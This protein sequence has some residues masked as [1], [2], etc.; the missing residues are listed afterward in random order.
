MAIDIVGKS[1]VQS[2]KSLEVKLPPVQAQMGLVTPEEGELYAT[3]GS[4]WDSAVPWAQGPRRMAMWS[5]FAIGGEAIL[6][7]STSTR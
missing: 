6:P 5:G 1:D 2:G 4:T 7:G 3:S